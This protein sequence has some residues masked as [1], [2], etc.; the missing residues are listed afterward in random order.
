MELNLSFVP[1]QCA[2]KDFSIN[3]VKAQVFDFG[4]KADLMPESRSVHECGEMAFIFNEP[5]EEVLT[6]YSIT[7]ANFNTICTQLSHGI[8]HTHCTNCDRENR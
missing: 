1:N 6:K 8:H 7:R 5:T 2:I 4:Y 3:G